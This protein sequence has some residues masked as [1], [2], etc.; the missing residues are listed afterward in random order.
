MAECKIFTAR[1]RKGDQGSGGHAKPTTPQQQPPLRP[2]VPPAGNQWQTHDPNAMDPRQQRTR[3][4]DAWQNGTE[5][6]WEE[7]RRLM[8]AGTEDAA[9]E[10]TIVQMQV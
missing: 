1:S 10:E 7:L 8:D 6:E 3:L 2:T 9:L 5:N 4:L